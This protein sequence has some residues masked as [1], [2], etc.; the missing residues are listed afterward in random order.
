M[1]DL[2]GLAIAM[3]VGFSVAS[4][5]ELLLPGSNFN[6]IYKAKADC[7]K[8]LPRDQHCVIIAIPEPKK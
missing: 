2:L 8:S 4:L 6:S 7:E 1:K 5:T 3:I